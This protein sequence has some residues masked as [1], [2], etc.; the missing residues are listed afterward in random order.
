MVGIQ[1]AESLGS[2]SVDKIQKNDGLI[3][4]N[5]LKYAIVIC[6]D[7][8]NDKDFFTNPMYGFD[9]VEILVKSKPEIVSS[10][11]SCLVYDMVLRLSGRFADKQFE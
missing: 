8:W 4:I 6:E 2:F 1:P 3:E 10:I 11:E 9:P 7:G 5:G